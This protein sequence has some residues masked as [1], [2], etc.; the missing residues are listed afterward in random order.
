MADTRNV[1]GFR[2]DGEGHG[3]YHQLSDAPVAYSIPLADLV[4]ADYDAK[5]GVR[6]IEFVGK[7]S[8]PI[9]TYIAQARRQERP[10]ALPR[11]GQIPGTIDTGEVAKSA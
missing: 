2:R 1:I 11:R 8:A 4:V 3:S 10:K 6:G 7:R 5:G 9:E